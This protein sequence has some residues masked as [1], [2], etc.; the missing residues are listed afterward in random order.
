LHNI[1]ALEPI[2]GIDLM[3]EIRKPKKDLRTLTNGPSKLCMS[4]KIIKNEF[5]K[6]DLET[7]KFLWIQDRLDSIPAENFK[8][9]KARRIGIDYA[10]DEAIN[11]LYR[12]YIKDNKFVSVKC[13]NELEEII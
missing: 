9:I 7:N 13:K 1:R 12:F 5:N 6:E 2:Y 8:I 3:K 10:G 11:K 4:F